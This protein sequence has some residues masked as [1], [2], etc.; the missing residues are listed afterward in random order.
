[1]TLLF[2]LESDMTRFAFQ[3]IALDDIG[4][5]CRKARADTRSLPGR[6]LRK[7]CSSSDWGDGRKNAKE[8]DWEMFRKQNPQDVGVIQDR[9]VFGRLPRFLAHV[10][11][12]PAASF[13][14]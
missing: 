8:A 5:D 10:I 1:M 4:M 3:S 6:K 13:Q 11:G 12:W 9:E 7:D 2:H 14:D